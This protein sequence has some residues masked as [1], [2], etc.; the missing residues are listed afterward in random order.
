MPLLTNM[1]GG[2]ILQSQICWLTCN[3]A[4]MVKADPL[5]RQLCKWLSCFFLILTVCSVYYRT[6]HASQ[7]QLQNAACHAFGRLFESTDML[8]SIGEGVGSGGAEQYA[9]RASSKG[10]LDHC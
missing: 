3:L 7:K 4:S 1:L 8:Q 2:Y 10:L 9:G 6:C 5:H